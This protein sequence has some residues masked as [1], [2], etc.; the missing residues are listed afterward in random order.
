MTT[1]QIIGIAVA[2]LAVLL[3]IVAL[4]VTR[5]RGEAPDP[6][7]H[8]TGGSFLDEAPQDTFSVLGKAE[9]P[10][11]DITIDPAMERA[12]AAQRAAAAAPG[13]AGAGARA[14]TR[15]SRPGLGPGPQ[16]AHE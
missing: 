3:L 8:R 7:P 6:E 11:E 14:S 10:V 5:R 16:R 13:G 2:A 15:R 1:V 9:R 4:I 12:A